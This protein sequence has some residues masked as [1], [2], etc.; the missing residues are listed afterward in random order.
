MKIASIAEGAGVYCQVGS[1]S[2]T[3]LGITA[4]VHF[5]KV[6]PGIIHFDLDSPLMQ[7]EDPVEGGMVYHKD[8]SVT[9]SD[10]PGH[11]ADFDPEFL[12]RFET[13]TVK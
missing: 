10:A 13:F 1:F 2:E 8:W 3:R 9:V 6:W 11:G 5:S 12:K 4:L 7:S